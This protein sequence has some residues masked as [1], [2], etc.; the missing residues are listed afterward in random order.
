MLIEES[1]SPFET[2]VTLALKKGKQKSRLCIDLKNLN[3]IVV[4]QAQLFPIIKNLIEK[5]NNYNY[6]SSLNINSAFWSVPRR[7]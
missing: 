3:K 2:S 6:S 1:Y 4:L 7:I 5:T